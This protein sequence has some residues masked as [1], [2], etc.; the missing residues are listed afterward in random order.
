M[1]HNK[2]G[3]GY[4]ERQWRLDYL[5]NAMKRT[6]LELPQLSNKFYGKISGER[7]IDVEE[8]VPTVYIE[9]GRLEQVRDYWRLRGH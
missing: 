2:Y 9:D 3:T 1:D 7:Q 6:Y 4:N 8:F 5:L